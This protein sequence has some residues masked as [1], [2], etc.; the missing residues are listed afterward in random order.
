FGRGVHV[1]GDGRFDLV[2]WVR[3]VTG[4]G[5]ARR[6]APGVEHEPAVPAEAEDGRSVLKPRKDL[7]VGVSR[8]AVPTL[9]VDA[10]A[11]RRMQRAR[12]CVTSRVLDYL[13]RDQSAHGYVTSGAERVGTDLHPARFESIGRGEKRERE[14]NKGDRTSGFQGSSSLIDSQSSSHKSRGSIHPLAKRQPSL[15]GH[16]AS[17]PSLM[18]SPARRSPASIRR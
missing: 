14:Q 8:G 9:S 6:N 5:S 15:C 4:F 7:P 13:T 1:F 17:T 2:F 16:N 12:W 11:H 10:G 3:R 18:L